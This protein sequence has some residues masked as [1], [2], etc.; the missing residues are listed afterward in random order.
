MDGQNNVVSTWT[1]L[2]QLT[3]HTLR[4]GVSDQ[5]IENSLVLKVNDGPQPGP[6]KDREDFP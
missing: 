3:S 5:D 1:I 2:Q 4:H 6:I